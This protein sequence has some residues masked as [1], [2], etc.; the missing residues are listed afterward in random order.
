MDVY[1]IRHINIHIL[2][3]A[4]F[5]S[6]HVN[7]SRTLQHGRAGNCFFATLCFPTGTKRG[8]LVYSTKSYQKA[9][10]T[11]FQCF[12][13]IYHLFKLGV[14]PL[15]GCCNRHPQDDM[16]F[17]CWM[18]WGFQPKKP[19][20]TGHWRKRRGFTCSQSLTHVRKKK[21]SPYMYS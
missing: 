7:R 18:V 5:F 4:T 10:P 16:A 17:T 21:T 11:E 8:N 3:G 12:C 1:V 6:A 20:A 19:E 13:E 14:E 2:S 15:T 9:M